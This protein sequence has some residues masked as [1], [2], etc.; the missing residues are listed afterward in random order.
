M[1]AEGRTKDYVSLIICWQFELSLPTE[2]T[3]KMRLIVNGHQQK[4]VV[5][6]NVGESNNRGE[7]LFH[8]I[9]NKHFS[10]ASSQYFETKLFVKVAAEAKILFFYV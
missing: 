9:E 10:T 8:H 6:Q 4:R 1:N 5:D 7:E 3:L 2:N